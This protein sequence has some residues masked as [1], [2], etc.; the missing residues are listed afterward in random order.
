M[1]LWD[2]VTVKNDDGDATEPKC[3]TRS[4]PAVLAAN[5]GNKSNAFELCPSSDLTDFPAGVKLHLFKRLS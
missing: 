5:P 4:D 3:D 1:H 2:P